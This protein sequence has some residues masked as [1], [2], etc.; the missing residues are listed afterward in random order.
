MVADGLGQEALADAGRAH[1]EHVAGF[2][3]EAAGGQVEDL[4]L[5]DRRVER[6]VE[7][8][9]GLQFAEAGGLDSP[10]QLAVGADGQFVL[11]DQFQE[12]GVVEAV[13]GRFLQADVER[14]Q[15]PREPQL[16]Q[17]GDQ[18]VGHDEAPF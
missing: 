13:A 9:E 11:E 2:A 17:G 12:L 5:L 1:E 6:P 10:L 3:D 15:Q 16:L 4:L 7:V 14:L 8:V 18:A